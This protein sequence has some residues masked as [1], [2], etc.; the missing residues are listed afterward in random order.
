MT[1]SPAAKRPETI[2]EAEKHKCHLLSTNQILE[3][4][5]DPVYGHPLMSASLPK[6]SF[7]PFSVPS[8]RAHYTLRPL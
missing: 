6:E 7:P 1:K 4:I 8:S 3:A 5:A 2:E